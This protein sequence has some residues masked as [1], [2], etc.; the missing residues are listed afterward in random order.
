MCCRG[1]RRGSQLLHHPQSHGRAQ[2]RRAASLEGR[3][4]QGGQVRAAGTASAQEQ[5]VCPGNSSEPPRKGQ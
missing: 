4:G 1:C 3:A 2:F 5:T